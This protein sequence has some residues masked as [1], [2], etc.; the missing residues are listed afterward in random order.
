MGAVLLSLPADSQK[1]DHLLQRSL[2][3]EAKG[4]DRPPEA[5]EGEQREHQN[6]L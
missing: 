2:Q 4:R 1:L 5:L 6:V 3:R